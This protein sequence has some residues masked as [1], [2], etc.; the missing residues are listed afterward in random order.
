MSRLYATSYDLEQFREAIQYCDRGARRFPDTPEFVECRLWLMAAPRGLEPDV[1]QAWEIVDEHL[2]L[3]PEADQE[4]ARI[5]DRLVVASILARADLPDSAIAVIAT[6]QAT[7]DIDPTRE[8]LGV[9]A[10]AHL[11]LGDPATA[12]ERLKIY[13]TASPEHRAGWR[14]SSHWWWRDLQENAEFRRLIGS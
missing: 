6:A 11:R 9:E 4:R 8:L 5:Q 7:P 12:L 10:L 2:A 3:V 14:W 13:L 1:D